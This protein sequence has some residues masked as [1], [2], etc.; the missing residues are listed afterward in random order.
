MTSTRVYLFGLVMSALGRSGHQGKPHTSGPISVEASKGAGSPFP[1]DPQICPKIR[2]ALN[3]IRRDAL[4]QISNKVEGIVDDDIRAN[5]FLLARIQGGQSDGKWKLVIPEAFAINMNHPAECQL[6]FAVGQGATGVAFRD[7]TYQL[8]RRQRSKK[9]N[10]DLK[11]RMTP[12][13]EEQV[14]ARL[15]WIVSFPLLRPNTTSEAIGVLNIDGL[16]DVADDDILNRL[17]TSVHAKV[18]VIA[19]TLSLQKSICVGFEEL[20]VME[21]V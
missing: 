21:H 15:K 12:E 2:D 5:I 3:E 18:S 6:Q 1:P 17:A 20:G 16:A 9:G 10:W 7:G 19:Q 14:E 8:T 13:L 11:F 4:N